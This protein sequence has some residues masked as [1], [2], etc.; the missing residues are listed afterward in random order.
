MDFNEFVHKFYRF[1]LEYF[2]KYYGPYKALVTSN[3]DPDGKGRVQVK[4]ARAKL[5][6]GNDL[7]FLPANMGAGAGYGTFWPPEPGD[8]VFVFFDNGDPS[9]PACY[10]GGWYA[11]G[12]LAKD[13][14]PDA[15]GSPKRRGFV[16]PAGSKVIMDD[17]QGSELITIEHK[18]GQRI[19]I[20]GN[21]IQIG[22]KNGQ[23]EPMLKG[24]T[25][26]SWLV[27][28][29]HTSPLGATSPPIQ[30]FPVDGLS[31]DTKNS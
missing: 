25:V 26:K 23:Y 7:W 18:D 20:S 19:K 3:Q 27:S 4:C 29:S 15:S 17:T 13:L 16:T 21:E 8:A 28:H 14:A 24:S 10:L 1:G 12:E 31:R 6:D 9:Y 11:K 5:P 30:P 22:S 2:R